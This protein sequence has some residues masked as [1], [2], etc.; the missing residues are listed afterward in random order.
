MGPAD[1]WATLRTNLE[2]L[3]DTLR[4]ARA[5]LVVS[6]HWEEPVIRV[7]TGANPDLYFDYYGFP[8]HTYELTWPAPG[9]PDVAE[10]AIRLLHEAGLDARPDSTRGF[11]HG[12]FIPLKVALP[13]AQIPTFQVSLRQ[14]LD[15][16][17]HLAIGRAL[18]P[19]RDEGVAII[20]SGMSF[21]N[22]HVLMRE[23][24][25]AELDQSRRFNRWIEA[26]CTR[27]AGDREQGLIR[28]AAAPSARFCHPREEH[29]LPLMVAAGAAH[30][31]P[32]RVLF[33]DQVLGIEVSALSFGTP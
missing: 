8:P 2:G 9:A 29:L 33:R 28:W 4:D 20:G 10:Q 23:S 3:G 22:M 18:A 1:T 17:E 31:E 6:A 16:E 14:G 30:S 7:Q 27:A 25:T 12:V 32:G 19:L 15:P 26:T 5:L 13:E 11:D 21:H 24:G